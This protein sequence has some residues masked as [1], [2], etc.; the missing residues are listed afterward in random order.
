MEVSIIIIGS[1]LLI[2]G[3]IGCFIPIIPGPPISFLSLLLIHFFSR[4]IDVI[5]LIVLFIL[6]F[7]VTFL[8]YFLQIYGVKKLGGGKL[9]IRGSIIGLII[10]LIF[11]PPF[12]ILLGSFAGAYIGSIIEIRGRDS[13]TPIRVA[14][15]AL[16][17]F[18]GGALLKVLITLYIIY[19]FIYNLLYL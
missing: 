2:I 15:G 1:I 9:A 16:I 8:D 10:G 18:L 4:Q 12:G 7:I 13:I 14:F 6:V 5:V 3:F 11:I 17:G 19:L